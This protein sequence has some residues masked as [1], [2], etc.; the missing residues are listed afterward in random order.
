MVGVSWGIVP[1]IPG[2]RGG[3][4]HQEHANLEALCQVP[5]G[6]H[7]PRRW[8]TVRLTPEGLT[9]GPWWSSITLA[10]PRPNHRCLAWALIVVAV[11]GCVRRP[12]REFV[13]PSRIGATPAENVYL[14]A[15]M[16]DGKV[17][18]LRSWTVDS[19]HNLVTGEGRILG[20]NRELLTTGRVQVRGE[21]SACRCLRDLSFGRYFDFVASARRSSR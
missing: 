7:G 16:R 19:E 13:P 14:K 18:I 12:V 15:H 4:F 6:E 2:A 3:G 17:Y 9:D 5:T 8:L 1:V 11:L 21:S 20:I 10:M